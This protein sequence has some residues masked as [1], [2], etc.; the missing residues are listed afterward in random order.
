MKESLVEPLEALVESGSISAAGFCDLDGEDVALHPPTH[1]DAIRNL[2]AVGGVA[3]RRLNMA[4]RLAGRSPLRSVTIDG[5]RRSV[6]SW[7][8]SDEYQLVL[9]VN[10]D[11]L[12]AQVKGL[13]E[14]TVREL[15][16]KI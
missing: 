12:P 9:L 16:E 5:T 4:E 8:V 2:A 3:L 15:A 13:V 1:R 10:E 6:M 14:A 7:L 11:A